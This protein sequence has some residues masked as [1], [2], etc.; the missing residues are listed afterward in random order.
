M[1]SKLDGL[2]NNTCSIALAIVAIYLVAQI[3]IYLLGM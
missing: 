1:I 3:L 2:A